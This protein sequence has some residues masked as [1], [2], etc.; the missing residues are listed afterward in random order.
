[1]KR[2][3]G[4][5]SALAVLMFSA[6][7]TSEQSD[8]QREAMSPTAKVEGTNAQSAVTIGADYAAP[9]SVA[10]ARLDQDASTGL[11]PDYYTQ[12]NHALSATRMGGT[13]VTEVRFEAPQYYLS[14]VDSRMVGWYPAIAPQA[15]VLTFD[16]SD[17]A[18]DV[19]LT[20]E[21]VGNSDDKIGAD[22]Q[23]FFFRH[24]LC[25]LIVSVGATSDETVQRWATVD[26]VVV[27]QLP[28]SYIVTLP[29]GRAVA[30]AADMVL[31]RRGGAEKMLPVKLS[32]IHM[33]E[34]GY[35]LTAP[36]GNKLTVE[37][38]GGNG[39]KRVVEASLPEGE[40]FNSGCV[41]RLNLSADGGSL[42]PTMSPP[43]AWQDSIDLD[44]EF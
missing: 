16:I 13:D 42:I 40:S 20:Q 14:D 37:L 22:G 39:E 5:S 35:L 32:A 17:G 12:T 43:A 24:Q 41:Y 19:M 34:C 10:F 9:L 3:I 26:K 15:G 29:G 38:T 1:M 27:K 36:R 28:T 4:L 7:S 31:N 6:C 8:L 11:W 44:V 33:T 25:Q 21:L 18:T 30:G 2:R 23:P